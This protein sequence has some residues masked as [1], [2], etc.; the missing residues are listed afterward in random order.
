MAH[1]HEQWT[2]GK[3]PLAQWGRF[4]LE[5][6]GFV[7]ILL[8]V[9]L[10]TASYKSALA[11]ST[12]RA[13]PEAAHTAFLAITELANCAYFPLPTALQPPCRV[14]ASLTPEAI[15]ACLGQ[16]VSTRVES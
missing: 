15:A 13:Y 11:E 9:T 4:L 7:V 2:E 16:L 1:E 6:Y 14:P 10:W 5:W 3:I 8:A 12:A